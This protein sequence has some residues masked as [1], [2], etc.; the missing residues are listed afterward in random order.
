M[1]VCMF[2]GCS[3]NIFSRGF[4][5]GFSYTMNCFTLTRKKEKRQV[6]AT[7][8]LSIED[9]GIPETH[10]FFIDVDNND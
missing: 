8:C 4:L 3:M 7:N 1:Y 10:L 6:A 5:Q 9:Y 2:M